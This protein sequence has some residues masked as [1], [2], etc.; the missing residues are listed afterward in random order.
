M[1]EREECAARLRAARKAAG[2]S[3]D[4]AAELLGVKR[5]SYYQ[6]ELGKRVPS[7]IQLYHFIEV[8]GLDPSILFPEYVPPKK[9]AKK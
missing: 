1:I 5:P 6:Y 3:Q 8:L 2:L 9:P 7:W 4:R